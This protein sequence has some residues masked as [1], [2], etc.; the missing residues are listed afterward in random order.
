MEHSCVC[1][2]YNFPLYLGFA[3]RFSCQHFFWFMCSPMAASPVKHYHPEKRASLGL[4]EVWPRRWCGQA[5]RAL[6]IISS[7]GCF[8]LFQNSTVSYYFFPPTSCF[9]GVQLTFEIFENA[10]PLCA[11][12]VHLM[13]PQKSFVKSLPQQ[14]QTTV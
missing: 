13:A 3:V 9:L 8:R 5:C 14:I 2:L 11:N 4:L 12:T 10:L 6:I 7:F 1:Q